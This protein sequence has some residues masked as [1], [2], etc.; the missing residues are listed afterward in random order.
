VLDLP[1]QV[2]LPAID[3]PGVWDLLDIQTLE[4]PGLAQALLERKTRNS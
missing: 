2:L 3:Y 1:D 4:D